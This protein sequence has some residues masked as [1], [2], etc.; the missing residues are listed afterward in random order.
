M[1]QD[2]KISKAQTTPV[3][4]TNV[5]DLWWGKGKIRQIHKIIQG[6][7]KYSAT[8][9]QTTRSCRFLSLEEDRNT[10]ESVDEMSLI[11]ARKKSN[12]NL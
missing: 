10:K 4:K 8:G 12:P 6:R 3:L 9:F 11:G 7:V 5:M 1:L 2:I